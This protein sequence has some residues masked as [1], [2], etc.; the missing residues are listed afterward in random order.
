[1]KPSKPGVKDILSYI[2]ERDSSE[3]KMSEAQLKMMESLKTAVEKHN[4]L[5]QQKLAQNEKF[6]DLMAKLVGKE[7]KGK[8]RRHSSDD[9]D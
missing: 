2:K 3:S 5:M 6:I 1:M 8:K 7:R 4:E 9:F